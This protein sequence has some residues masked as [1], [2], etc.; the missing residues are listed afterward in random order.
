[1]IDI[2]GAQFKLN[3]YRVVDVTPLKWQHAPV[4][5][6]QGHD[7]EANDTDGLMAFI[8][9]PEVE[10]KNVQRVILKAGERYSKFI[11]NLGCVKE[12]LD[13]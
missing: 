3:C 4:L 8:T 1:M 12:E 6:A 10:K 9:K 7:T 11:E 5:E 2:H 13:D